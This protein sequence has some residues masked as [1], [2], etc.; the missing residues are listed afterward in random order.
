MGTLATLPKS[1]QNR[2]ENETKTITEKTYQNSSLVQVQLF[3]VPTTERYGP[4]QRRR[5][6]LWGDDQGVPYKE[7][8][9][10]KDVICKIELSDAALTLASL[11]KLGNAGVSVGS[12]PTRDATL[13]PRVAT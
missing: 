1:I 8:L 6:E 5:W 12:M 10:R 2:I 13:P 7:T 4:W 9:S 11:E 3:R